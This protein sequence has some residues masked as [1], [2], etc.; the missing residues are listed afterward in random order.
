VLEGPEVAVPI[1]WERFDPDLRL[2]DE[3]VGAAVTELVTSLVGLVREQAPA[4]A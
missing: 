4:A 2:T 1:A 3:N